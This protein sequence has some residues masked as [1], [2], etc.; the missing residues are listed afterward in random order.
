MSAK[1]IPC[2][3]QKRAAAQRELLQIQQYPSHIAA[4]AA[5][6]AAA[7]KIYLIDIKK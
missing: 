3:G 1:D 2:C 5:V 4:F 6:A 7:I